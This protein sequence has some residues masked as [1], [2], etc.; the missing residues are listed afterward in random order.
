MIDFVQWARDNHALLLQR[1]RQRLPRNSRLP[2][3]GTAAANLLGC[4][5]STHST[6]ERR[7]YNLLYALLMERYR[8]PCSEETRLLSEVWS[9]VSTTPRSELVDA[10]ATRTVTTG[11]GAPVPGAGCETD[12]HA[13]A[14]RATAPA[15]CIP[16]HAMPKKAR[17]S[18]PG[19]SLRGHTSPRSA[20]LVEALLARCVKKRRTTHDHGRAVAKYRRVYAWASA[21]AV[22]YASI[23]SCRP[24]PDSVIWVRTDA[25]GG[26][27]V[28]LQRGHR[29]EVRMP[30]QLRSDGVVLGSCVPL[31]R[32][33][34]SPSCLMTRSLPVSR[35]PFPPGRRF[36]AL[37]SI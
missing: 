17:A 33:V 37:I 4:L 28:S 10:D 24:P 7:Y 6:D 12:T 27:G 11:A 9:S 25:R 1:A 36:F 22:R 29:D 26:R 5:R 23:I 32:E 19:M 35:P 31:V 21:D 14:L 20:L 2:A 30:A 16:E 34:S 13:A 18:A 15:V 3:I 8:A